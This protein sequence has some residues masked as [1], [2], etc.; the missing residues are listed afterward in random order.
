MK[1]RRVRCGA[2]GNEMENQS[3]LEVAGSGLVYD[4]N[5]QQISASMS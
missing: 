2:R 3:V 5:F 1:V 4:D